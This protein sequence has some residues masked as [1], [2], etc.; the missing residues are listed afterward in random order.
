MFVLRIRRNFEGVF[1]PRRRGSRHASEPSPLSFLSGPFSL[2]FVFARFTLF[3][4]PSDFETAEAKLVDLAFRTRSLPQ[5]LPP[6]S[7][8]SLFCFS[9][10]R[11]SSGPCPICR[12]LPCFLIFPQPV[13]FSATTSSPTSPRGQCEAFMVLT[14]FFPNFSLGVFQSTEPPSP[15]ASFFQALLDA[16]RLSGGRRPLL[17]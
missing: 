14:D 4:I 6:P 10:P 12:I 5:L 2:S 11:Q 7:P 9:P 1:P 8:F 13:R 15:G 3:S 17:R 16:L